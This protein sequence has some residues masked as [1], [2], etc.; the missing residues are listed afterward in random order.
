MTSRE[1]GMRGAGPVAAAGKGCGV[2][3]DTGPAGCGQGSA[4]PGF[5][6]GLA[7][8]DDPAWR[9]A[10]VLV[11][12]GGKCVSP[13]ADVAFRAVSTDS[14]AV[15]AGDLFV[16]LAGDRFD[17]HDFVADAV[18]RGAAGVLV[19]RLPSRDL[20][21]QVVR[22]PDTLTALGDLAAYRRRLLPGLKVVAVTGSCG[23][24]TVK[25]MC[26]AILGR[27]HPL[28]KT[29]GNYNNLVGMPLSL[30]PVCR[31]HRFAVLEMGMNRRGEIARLTA[32]AGPDAAC[33][34]NVMAAHIG[35]L[36]SVAGVAAAKEELFASA[37]GHAVLAVNADDQ[38]VRRMARRY[39][40]PKVTFGRRP[41]VQV[42]GLR[43]RRAGLAGMGFT[44][45]I[46]GQRR[47]VRL[48]AFGSH[49][50]A[51]ALAAAAL[52]HAVGVGID[53]IAA[54]LAS[55]EPPAMR[56]RVAEAAGVR[57]VD[58]TYNANPGSMAAAIEAVA[59]LRRAGEERF[60][61]VLGDMFELGDASAA[62]HEEVGRKVAACGCDLLVAVGRF[63]SR[64]AAG[65]RRAGLDEVAACRDHDA[66]VRLLRDLVAAGR[67]RTGDW[68]LLK[69]SRGMRMEAVR[70][71]LAA[72][73][74]QEAGAGG[75]G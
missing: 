61:A 5:G 71:A 60:V 75:G 14:R 53:D 52:A 22:V 38:W 42:R 64:L 20:P 39:A 2:P 74:A 7:L 44:L 15:Q 16:A 67:I 51:D 19:S 50:L 29:Q 68:V 6:Y 34:T 11:A 1:G 54:G 56:M 4:P 33:I 58:D 9:L 12:T 28:V 36:G 73:L 47:R 55:F 31:H 59:G 45:E 24:T 3:V 37:P 69:G 40:N 32:I 30:L 17:G 70:D 65:A 66:A 25:E 72:L 21:V 26:A 8:A 10:D 62:L 48:P 23:K 13:P 35:G 46:E 49:L 41:G 18:R 57:L 43:P 63:A 27:C